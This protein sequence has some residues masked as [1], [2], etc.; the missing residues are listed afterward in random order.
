ML[1]KKQSHRRNSWKYTV[2]LPALIAFVFLFQ[3]KVEAQEKESNHS[4]VDLTWTKNSSDQEFKEDAKNANKIVTFDFTKIK[5]NEKNEI[6]SITIS[7][8]DNLGNK[9]TATFENKNGINPI[10][11]IR[12]IDEN[13]KGKIGYFGRQDII[14]ED[15]DLVDGIEINEVRLNNQKEDIEEARRNIE[16]A[17]IDIE[18]AKL[19]IELSKKNV[20]TPPI[21]PASRKVS[22]YKTVEPNLE[23]N[24]LLIIN[25]KEYF[26]NDLKSLSLKCDGSITYYEEEEAIKKF[27]EKGKDG[28]MVFNGITKLD[29]INVSKEILERKTIL[30]SNDNGDDIVFIPTEKILK[31]PGY[32]SIKLNDDGLI[33]IVNGIQKSNPLETLNQTNLQNV[34]SVRVY[35]ENGNKTR[36]SLTKKIVITTK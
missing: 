36:G 33:L 4:I 2:V 25:G 12:D 23:K 22:N 30:F 21:P 8:K 14:N 31:L 24:R 27:G 16:Q 35:D 6:T 15:I 7:F 29:K 17:K 3:I 11:F 26:Q 19:D 13:G 5:R 20:P 1:N 18:Q 32:P 10:H 9:D 28:V 34:K